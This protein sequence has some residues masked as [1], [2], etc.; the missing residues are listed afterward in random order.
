[1]IY[2][3]ILALPIFILGYLTIKDIISDINYSIKNKIKN[4]EQRSKIQKE[5]GDY[6]IY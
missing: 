1:M 4:N 3:I 2:L 5:T 6:R